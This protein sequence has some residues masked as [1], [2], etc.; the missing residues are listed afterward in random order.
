MS[1][2][3]SEDASRPCRND[4]FQRPGGQPFCSGMTGRLVLTSG[5]D[6]SGSG[7][8]N[9]GSGGGNSGSGSA[10]SGSGRVPAPGALPLM[11]LAAFGMAAGLGR[12]AHLALSDPAC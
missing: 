8:G 6:N 10:N 3:G 7:G 11:A 1:Y 5:S 12:R 2:Y 4:P 9:S